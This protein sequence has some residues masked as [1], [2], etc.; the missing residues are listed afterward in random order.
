MLRIKNLHLYLGTV[1]IGFR[2][3]QQSEN[4]CRNNLRQH[5]YVMLYS[6]GAR[7]SREYC[8][9]VQRSMLSMTSLVSVLTVISVVIG[10]CVSLCEVCDCVC[11]SLHEHVIASPV[12]HQCAVL[13]SITFHIALKPKLH[14]AM[15]CY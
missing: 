5:F 7:Q 1:L 8:C 9:T 6:L 3:K 14:F 11:L 2:C 4:C 10:P 13:A 12:L 15:C